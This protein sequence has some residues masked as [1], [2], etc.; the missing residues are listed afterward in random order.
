MIMFLYVDYIDKDLR[1]IHIS[2]L[3]ITI[4]MLFVIM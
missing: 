1:K 2:L 4:I 3:I